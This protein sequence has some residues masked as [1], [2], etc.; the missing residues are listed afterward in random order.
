MDRFIEKK[1]DIY[2]SLFH[3]LDL[4]SIPLPLPF[5]SLNISSYLTYLPTPLPTRK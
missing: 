1:I 4:T 2:F 3:R 5:H